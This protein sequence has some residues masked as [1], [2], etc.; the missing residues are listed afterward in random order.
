MTKFERI[1]RL[2][3]GSAVVLTTACGL[4]L[5]P[6]WHIAAAFA[7]LLYTIPPRA[8]KAQAFARR[9]Q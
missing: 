7:A 5:S 1:E 4:T 6:H 3:I 2:C 9:A 8:A